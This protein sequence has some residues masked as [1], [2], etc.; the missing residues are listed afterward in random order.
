MYKKE[1]KRPK[2]CTPEFFGFLLRV[3]R[4]ALFF[5]FP[6][7]ALLYISCI[8]SVFSRLFLVVYYAFIHKKK[9]FNMVLASYF[10]VVMCLD[11][12]ACSFLQFI[13][14]P[15]EAT[16]FPQFIKFTCKPEK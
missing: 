12:F 16:L 9:R 5:A 11:L 10:K 1:Q 15:R 6:L 8:L 2:A 13:K 4:F 7:G 3:G 14:N